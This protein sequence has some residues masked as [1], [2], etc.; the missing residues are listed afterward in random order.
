[1][2]GGMKNS[3]NKGRLPRGAT[4][5]LGVEG[6]LGG[7]GLRPRWEKEGANSWS[8]NVG[9][10]SGEAVQWDFSCDWALGQEESS[11]LDGTHYG[12]L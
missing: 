4:S 12:G 1:M 6:Q 5:E 10:C 9:T 8:R 3:W 2:C 7:G 11:Q